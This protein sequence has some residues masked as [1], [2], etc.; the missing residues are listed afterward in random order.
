MTGDLFAHLVLVLSFD[1]M[2]SKPSAAAVRAAK[3]INTD[4]AH[5]WNCSAVN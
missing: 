1:M 4:I 5:N 2:R 3:S